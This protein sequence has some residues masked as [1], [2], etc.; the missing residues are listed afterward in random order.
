[1]AKYLIM[2]PVGGKLFRSPQTPAFASKIEAEQYA[3]DCASISYKYSI[4]KVS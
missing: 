2:E 4:K 3:K 1:M